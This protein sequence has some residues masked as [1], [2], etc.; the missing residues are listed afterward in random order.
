V[1]HR[2]RSQECE[3]VALDHNGARWARR[4]GFLNGRA[5]ITRYRD[6]CVC[7]SPDS[8]LLHIC[9]VVRVLRKDSRTDLHTQ[10]SASAE[11]PIDLDFHS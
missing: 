7:V 4:S 6:A 2:E 1:S 10:P 9:D 5:A 11:L 3:L 8:V